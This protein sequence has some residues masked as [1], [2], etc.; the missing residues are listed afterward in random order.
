MKTMIIM[1]GAAGLLLPGCS[2]VEKPQGSSSLTASYKLRT[3][4]VTLPESARVP[5]VVAAAEQTVRARGY[6]VSKSTWTEETGV[7]VARPPRTGDYP[8][9]TIQAS[10]VTHGTHV[11]LTV[12]PFGDQEMSRSVLDGTLQRL[13]L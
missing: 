13:G 3:L 1:L 8:T 5:A 2:A 6:S 7:L 4:S 10:A 9:I 12:A 11:E